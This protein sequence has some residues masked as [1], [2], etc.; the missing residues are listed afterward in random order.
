MILSNPK[1]QLDDYSNEL[2]ER[3][4]ITVKKSQLSTILKKMNI[5]RKKVYFI[6]SFTNY[7]SLLKLP[8]GI[9][10]SAVLGF[11]NWG[12]GLQNN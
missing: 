12:H 4:D 11:R 7:S 9:P 3:F 8:N 5:T 1:H 10:S 6:D 2:K